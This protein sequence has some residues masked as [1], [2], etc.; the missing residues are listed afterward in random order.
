M[1]GQQQLRWK[2][3]KGLQSWSN[4][5]DLWGSQR[6]KAGEGMEMQIDTTWVGGG[7]FLG[8]KGLR[9][10]ASGE[11]CSTKELLQ[12]KVSQ[13]LGGGYRPGVSIAS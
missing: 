3:S 2:W 1:G 6:L 10:G 7:V 4:Q 12:R 11:V 8:S 5:A 13:G 9:H